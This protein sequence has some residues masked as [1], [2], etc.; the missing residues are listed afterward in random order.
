M[1]NPQRIGYTF[2][3]GGILI[4]QS[5]KKE[6]KLMFEMEKKKKKV[7]NWKITILNE[8]GP[9][10]QLVERTVG[11]GKEMCSPKPGNWPSQHL[12]LKTNFG[13]HV[14]EDLSEETTS[15]SCQNGELQETIKL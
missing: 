7:K 3:N 14:R 6:G 2:E 13:C 5:R 8:K 15:E 11:N 4:Q 9:S 10:A 1:V 12:Y